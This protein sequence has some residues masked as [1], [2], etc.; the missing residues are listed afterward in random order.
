METWSCGRRLSESLEDG[1]DGRRSTVCRAWLGTWDGE[2]GE[3]GRSSRKS[4]PD[5]ALTAS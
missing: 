3:G 2:Q 1:D 5:C 4:A